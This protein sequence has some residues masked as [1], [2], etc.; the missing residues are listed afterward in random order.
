MAFVR[1]P[2]AKSISAEVVWRPKE[3]LM[4]EL[5]CSSDSP[6]AVRTCDGAGVPVVQAEPRLAA[7]S[8]QF[9]RTSSARQPGN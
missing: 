5:A 4:V 3:N 2:I 7:K 9:A 6:M 1:Q 8:G